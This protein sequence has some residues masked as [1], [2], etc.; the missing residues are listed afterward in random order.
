M[1][2]IDTNSLLGLGTGGNGIR[3]QKTI[4]IS[5]PIDEVYRFWH[6]FENFPLF[7]DHVKEV[8]V[9]NGISTWKVAGPAGSS[10]EFQAHITRDVPNESI[11]WETIPNS[12]IHHAGVVHFER[13]WDGGTRVTVQMTYMPPAGVVGHKV[14][15]LFGVDPRQAMQDDLSRLKVLLEVNKMTTEENA[16]RSNEPTAFS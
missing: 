4:N 10:I 5:A 3:V 15:E 9:Q 12:Q 13:N 14:A 11:A 2:N 16:T 6:N 7:M 8:V 1:T